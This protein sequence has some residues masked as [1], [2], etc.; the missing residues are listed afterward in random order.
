MISDSEYRHLKEIVDLRSGIRLQDTMEKSVRRFV[1]ERI[2][3]RGIDFNAYLQILDHD[4]TEQHKFINTVTI[5]ETYFFREEKYFRLLEEVILPDLN[6]TFDG[7]L[8]IWSAAASFGAEALSIAMIAERMNQ[9]N[10][11]GS[12]TVYA[13]DIDRIALQCLANN[14]FGDYLLKDDGRK[15]HHLISGV[16]ENINGNIVFKKNITSRIDAFHFNLVQDSY[17]NIRFRPHVVFLRNVLTYMD[18]S[19]KDLI[20][21]G[22]AGILHPCG[23]LI[24]SSSDTAFISNPDLLL[25]ENGNT[26]YFQKIRKE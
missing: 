2:L 26:F 19:R 22:I 5:N 10:L 14:S 12:Y 9:N 21:N 20:I 16:S 15:Y 13:S 18:S 24:V 25:R 17:R 4:E 6:S 23:Y 7:G 1:A 8:N 11:I 3:D